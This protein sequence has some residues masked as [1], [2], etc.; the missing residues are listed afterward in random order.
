MKN[1]CLFL[2]YFLFVNDAS[3]SSRWTKYSPC[4]CALNNPE[5]V[6]IAYIF[7]KYPLYIVMI[8]LKLKPNK[9]GR[10]T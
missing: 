5:D 6:S 10:F 1:L 7:K 4:L 3:I 2:M 8:V 9:L